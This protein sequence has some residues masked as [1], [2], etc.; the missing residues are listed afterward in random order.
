[1]RYKATVIID[2]NMNMTEAVREYLEKF[3]K[4]NNENE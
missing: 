3:Y 2:T 1:M 4:K